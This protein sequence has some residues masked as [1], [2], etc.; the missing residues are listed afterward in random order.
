MSTTRNRCKRRSAL[1][2]I[3]LLIV[4]GVLV[5]LASISLGAMKTLLR[6]QKVSQASVTVRQY[7]QNA[8]T[9]AVASGRPVAVFLDRVSMIAGDMTGSPTSANFTSTRLQLGEVFPPYTGDF[10][11]AQGRLLYYSEAPDAITPT[12][13]V[14]TVPS[15]FF[16]VLAMRT[17]C[18]LTITP[19]R[20]AILL[21]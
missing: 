15:R 20:S 14:E 2:L 7:L 12:A 18:F 17:V 10:E 4:M 13:I 1:T 8:Q 16:N 6:G 3:E 19:H 5:I 9:R 11:N 21:K